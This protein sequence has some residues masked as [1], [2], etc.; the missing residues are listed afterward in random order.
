MQFTSEPSGAEVVVD[1]NS[2]GRT[3]LTVM[4][5]KNSYELVTFN[6]EG[7]RSVTKPLVKKYDGVAL[8]NIFWDLSTT[9][10]IS[11]AAF[12]YEPNMYHLVM[13]KEE[14]TSKIK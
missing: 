10:M 12:E 9:D 7:Y 14:T 13:E 6:K 4:L 5:K 1:G 2:M 11:G 8:L 3:P